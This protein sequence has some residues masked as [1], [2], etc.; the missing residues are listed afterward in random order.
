MQN[1]LKSRYF[2]EIDDV[3]DFDL[4]N[5][6]NSF[7]FIRVERHGRKVEF[8]RENI[9]SRKTFSREF[10]F[11]FVKYFHE[12][13]KISKEELDGLTDRPEE[14]LFERFCC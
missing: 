6:L 2:S 10:I 11:S 13:T 4:Q 14:Y 8:R 9:F 12:I 3:S 1:F 7:G 5:P